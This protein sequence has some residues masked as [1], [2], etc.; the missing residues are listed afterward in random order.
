MIVLKAS[1]EKFKDLLNNNG[2]FIE[3]SSESGYTLYLQDGSLIYVCDLDQENSQDKEEYENN[4]QSRKSLFLIPHDTEGKYFVRAESRP[5]DKTTT[6]TC[7]GDSEFE[8]GGG[9]EF[10]WDFSN[11]NDEIDM[12]SGSGLKRKRI[13]FSFI[14]AINIKEGSIYYQN[15]PKGCYLD[16]KVVCPAGNYYLDNNKEVQLATE[17]TVIECFVNKHFIYG[18]CSLGDELNSEAASEEIPITYKYWIEITT[19]DT[20]ITSFG[21]ASL[22]IFRKRTVV[23]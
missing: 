21:H 15:A 10:R 19:P 20:D 9:V 22:E 8:I 7:A 16:L 2:V 3:S 6:F 14:D 4:Y 13:E 5:I 1:W 12:P 18:N 23:L 11:D 17:D